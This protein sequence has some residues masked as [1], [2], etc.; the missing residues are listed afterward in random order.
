MTFFFDL[1]AVNVHS[2]LM[3]PS[4]LTLCQTTFNVTENISAYTVLYSA[5]S[6]GVHRAYRHCYWVKPMDA[7]LGRYG[8]VFK[9]P[10]YQFY[11]FLTLLSEKCF[12]AFQSDLS[13]GNKNANAVS[14]L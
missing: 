1:Q 7:E 13:Q 14:N 5:N 2:C 9:C 4:S 8:Y 3:P 12:A 6:H 11:L 10:G